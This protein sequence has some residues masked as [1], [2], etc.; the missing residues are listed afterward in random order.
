[1]PNEV[2]ISRRELYK[3]VWSTPMHTLAMKF[4]RSDVGLA[5]VCK[6]FNIP[7][8]G[9]G[10]WAKVSNG[11]PPC[12]DKLPDPDNN[13]QIIL[14]VHQPP[15]SSGPGTGF[16]NIFDRALA[17]EGNWPAI[18]VVRRKLSDEIVQ[19]MAALK[20]HKT[21]EWDRYIPQHGETL[22]IRVTD[23]AMH[24]AHLLMDVL[25]EQL[26]RRG[27]H[28]RPEGTSVSYCGEHVGIGIIEQMKVHTVDSKGKMVRSG[29]Y[30]FPP[31][32][33]WMGK[34]HSVPSGRL[35]LELHPGR[36]IWQRGIRRTWRDTTHQHINDC[37]NDIIVGIVRVADAQRK[38][39]ASWVAREAAQQD[40]ETK[41][42]IQAELKAK[43]AARLSKLEADVAAWQEAQSIRSYVTAAR[44]R[45]LDSAATLHHAPAWLDWAEKH[46]E[47]LDPL[48]SENI[49]G[50]AVP[51][52]DAPPGF[53][54][55]PALPQEQDVIV[56][57]ALCANGGRGNTG[58]R[59]AE[60]FKN[61]LVS[62]ACDPELTLIA[63]QDDRLLGCVAFSNIGVQGRPGICGVEIGLVCV[64]PSLRGKGIGTELVN[65]GICKAAEHGKAFICAQCWMPSTLRDK[66]NFVSSA[67]AGIRTPFDPVGIMFMQVEGTAI[68][69]KGAVL[70]YPSPWSQYAS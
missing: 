15:S 19:S 37:L 22:D 50:I 51:V 30:E 17:A 12:P 69:Q 21:D 3:Q 60:L 27:C 6:K 44:K 28:V 23:K 70:E 63:V 5:K 7:R 46:A 59:E 57:L 48:S 16:T 39:C 31:A 8:P 65:E 61:L 24:S 10:Y 14:C 62:G 36:T 25:L 54:V 68:V 11:M 1:M 56:K 34:Q 67:D 20:E 32:P 40:A 41:Q 2:H 35:T 64:D 52:D 33:P 9:R 45:I 49:D 18:S 55:R 26:D 38:E 43:R 47:K 42:K 58:Q 29:Y 13:P 53:Y 4:G 66:L